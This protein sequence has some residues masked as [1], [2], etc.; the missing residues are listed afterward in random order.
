[1]NFNIVF[2]RDYFLSLICDYFFKVF[3]VIVFERVLEVKIIF[4]IVMWDVIRMVSLMFM[5]I[6]YVCLGIDR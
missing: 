4:L 3:S 5:V 6:F 1:M 2:L